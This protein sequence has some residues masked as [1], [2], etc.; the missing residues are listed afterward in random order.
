MDPTKG[1]AEASGRLKPQWFEK[2]AFTRPHLS[3][4]LAD[5]IP[6][7][8]GVATGNRYALRVKRHA[9]HQ[10]AG[11]GSG[12]QPMHSVAIRSSMLRAKLVYSTSPADLQG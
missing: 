2:H 8:I 7:P 12:G 11:W 10:S 1:L 5:H 4:R 6:G 9:Q 3:F